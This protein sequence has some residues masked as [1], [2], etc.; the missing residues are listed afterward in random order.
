MSL[1]CAVGIADGTQAEV[2]GPTRELPVE[3]FYQR[4]RILLGVTR[5]RHFA[6]RLTHALY[7]FLGLS[8]A[9]IG[10]PCLRRVTSAKRIPE[11]IE[12]FS[13]QSTDPR[14]TFIHRQ[15]Q[16]RHHAPHRA[17]GLFGLGTTANH[18]I[19]GIVNDVRLQTLLVP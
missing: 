7:S 10:L 18:E 9:P 13:R 5:S 17:Q 6:D 15:L 1:H 2:V 8:L 14:L 12:R 19:I 4:F 11:K 16:P 3:R